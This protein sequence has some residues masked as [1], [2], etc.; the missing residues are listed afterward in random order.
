MNIKEEIKILFFAIGIMLLAFFPFFIYAAYID[1]NFKNFSKKSH[2]E[3]NKYLVSSGIE[4]KKAY[5]LENE[6]SCFIIKK[7]D[8]VLR[9]ICGVKTTDTTINCRFIK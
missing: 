7:D 9:L 6:P 1:Y 4:Y 3:F 2:E 5:C 8:T